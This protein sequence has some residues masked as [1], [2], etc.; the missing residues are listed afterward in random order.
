M[1][2]SAE[3]EP[4]GAL[5]L[6]VVL[7]A[8]CIAQALRCGDASARAACGE[9]SA[10]WT[11]TVPHVAGSA[12]HGTQVMRPCGMKATMSATGVDVLKAT[13]SA[14]GDDVLQRPPLEILREHRFS[15]VLEFVH[16]SRL[17]RL[18]LQLHPQ[19]PNAKS[20]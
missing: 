14:A 18:H 3:S 12:R 5:P 20:P 4:A 2:V 19:R 10:G 9:A 13:M 8:C 1:T 16:G 7:L 11:T 15:F 17:P 6:L